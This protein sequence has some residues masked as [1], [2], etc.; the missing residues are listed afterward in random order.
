[1]RHALITTF[2]VVVDHPWPYLA[3]MLG[4]QELEQE[5]QASIDRSILPALGRWYVAYPR[6]RS[7]P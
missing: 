1:M 7:V 3:R 5:E 6:S 2:D 4:V